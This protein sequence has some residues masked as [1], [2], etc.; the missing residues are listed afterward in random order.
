M[1]LGLCLCSY[2]Q[3]VLEESCQEKE[4]KN[5]RVQECEKLGLG[6]VLLG[7]GGS[8]VNVVQLKAHPHWYAQLFCRATSK[9]NSYKP[10]LTLQLS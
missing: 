9:R 2:L 3:S 5:K 4:E 6:T 7:S 10:S 8:G 1:S